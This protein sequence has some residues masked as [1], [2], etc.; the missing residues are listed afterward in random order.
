MRVAVDDHGPGLPRPGGSDLREVRARRKETATPGVG[1]GLAI[2]RAIVEAHG[3]T[4]CGETRPRR[5]ALHVELPLGT[6]PP[7]DETDRSARQ[8]IGMSD[9]RPVVLMVEDEP[10]IRRF[11]RTAAGTPRAPGACGRNG[12]KRGLSRP[13]RAARPGRAGSRP[14]RWRRRRPDPRPARLVGHAGHRA[15]GAHRPRRTRSPRWTPGPTTT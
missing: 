13:A 15:V 10:Q 6:P 7:L 11:V 8:G 2:C 1:L 3:G 9:R 14:A 12:L 4:I 5:R